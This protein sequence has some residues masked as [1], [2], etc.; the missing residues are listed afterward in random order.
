ML[1]GIPKE[2]KDHE[3]RV[4]ATP[5]T[6]RAFVMQGHDVIVETKAGHSIGFTDEMYAS[7]GARIAETKEE[8]YE[9]EM[10]IK[11]KEPQPTEYPLLREDQVL[12]CYLHLAPDPEQT[13]ALVESG[14][15]AIAYETIEDANG[16]LPLLTPM[17]EV[18]G[19][20]SIQAGATALQMANGGRGVLL[21]G[22]TGVKPG[23]VMI[24]GGGIVGTEAAKMAIGIG[25]DVTVFDRSISRLR[26]LENIFG[27][28]LKTMYSTEEAL[29][30]EI[31]DTDLLVGSVL[32]PGKSAP[33]VITREMVR[34]MRNGSVI[35][36][37]AI[38]QGG[39]TET[40]RPTTHTNPTY[41]EE[42][43]V[44]YCVTNMPGA[45]AYT[46]TLALTN[47]TFHYALKLANFGYR[48]AL[49]EDPLFMLGLNVCHGKVTYEAVA[50][51]L[52]YEY[53]DPRW[54][55]LE[56]ALA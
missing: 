48:K 15:V 29:F 33:K 6:V 22:V 37:V 54:A 52:G 49:T 56:E 55:L 31:L 35:A 20:I 51:D 2:V 28:R 10:I 44:H 4:G 11:V 5:S 45:C 26:E 17:S 12:F 1:I 8:V 30:Q 18:A 13:K 19:R 24:V 7:S 42:G 43:V 47:A 25:A 21:G 23:K 41:V 39:C 50:N 9:A 16:R 34:A 27:S 38:D 3:Y 40:S 32:I 14:C 46:S 36:D 53:S